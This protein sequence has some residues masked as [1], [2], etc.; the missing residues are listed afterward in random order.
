MTESNEL[1]INGKKIGSNYKLY[2]VAEAG[3]NHN[4]DIK[5]A[6][7]MIDKAIESGADAIKFQT[8]KSEEFLTESSEYFNFFK[9]VELSYEEFKEISDYAKSKNLTFF[10]APFDIPSADFLNQIKVPC[11]KIASSDLTN[12]PLIRHIAK[13]NKPMIISTGIG[14][15][16]EVE[17]AVN[18][19]LSEGNNQL[20]LLHCVANYPALPEEANLSA[21]NTLM[22]KFNFPVGYSDNGE[23]TLVAL[24]AVSMGACIIEKHYTLNKKFDGPDHSFSIEPSALKQLIS[25]LCITEKMKGTGKK[26]PNPSEI[27]NRNT[28]RK[29]ITAKIDIQ[30]GEKLSENNL[31]IKRPEGGIEPKFWDSVI[32]KQTNKLIK[33]DTSICWND[34]LQ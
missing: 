30:E 27:S 14:T 26:I 8:Y 33:K 19:C 34:I 20:A 28:I 16:E 10:S 21:I 24:A 3:L 13:M 12:M 25:Q 6:K 11:F 7:Q 5:I 23:S 32:N 15:L 9:S 29:S 22:N 4:G 1:K 2:F 31:S 17:D 18:W